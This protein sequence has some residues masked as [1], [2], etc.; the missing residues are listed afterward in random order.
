MSLVGPLVNPNK[1]EDRFDRISQHTRI[2]RHPVLI[3][4]ALLLG[5][6]TAAAAK[7][8]YV[9]LLARALA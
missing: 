9:A 5:A 3:A 6:A 8:G 2:F 1:L 4:L 7:L